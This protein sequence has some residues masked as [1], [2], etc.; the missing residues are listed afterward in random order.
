MSKKGAAL[1]KRAGGVGKPAVPPR[2]P[3]SSD[4]EDSDAE[5]EW[6]SQKH[7]PKTGGAEGGP[8]HKPKKQKKSAPRA[9]KGTLSLSH[10]TPHSCAH[11]HY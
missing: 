1:A 7:K 11:V 3:D 9:P 8:K 10:P 2:A 5:W 4:D 6:W